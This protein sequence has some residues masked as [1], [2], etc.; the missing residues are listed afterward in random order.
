MSDTPKRLR[1][2]AEAEEICDKYS[3]EAVAA[4]RKAADELERKDAEIEKLYEERRRLDHVVAD[5]FAEIKRLRKAL[6][7]MWT[8]ATNGHLTSAQ[9]IE[10]Q[11]A[12]ALFEDALTASAP[13]LT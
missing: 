9:E 4:M 6:E 1:D 5:Q 10:C 12:F 8:I 11:K 7:Q 2:A 3:T 13:D